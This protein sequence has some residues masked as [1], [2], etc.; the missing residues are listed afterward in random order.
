V[1]TLI[2]NCRSVSTIYSVLITG[3]PAG[4]SRVDGVRRSNAKTQNFYPSPIDMKFGVG[5]YVREFTSPAKFGL[6]PM[7][8]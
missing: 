6:D 3:S 7:S 1:I 8:G 2:C 5:D 4:L